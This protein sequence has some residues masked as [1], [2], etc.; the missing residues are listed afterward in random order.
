MTFYKKLAPFYNLAFFYFTISF[1]LRIVLFFHPIT[2][3][4]FT[5][6]QS[7]KIFSLGLI[8]DF[9]VFVVASIF[10]WLYL[11]FVSNTKYNKPSGHIILGIFVA[12]FLYVA[13]GKSIFDEYGGALPKIIL[14]FIGIKTLLFALLLFLPKWR[15]KIRFWLFAFV[16]FIYVLLILQNG[17]SEY[18]FWNEFGV[19]YNFIAVNYLIYTNEVIGNIMQSYPVIPLFTAFFLLT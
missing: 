13:S 10:L 7:L 14:I 9:F 4:S 2:Q 11:I 3:S 8:S 17:L 5:I 15:D 16:I 18:F 1:L 6:L 19:K 12:L